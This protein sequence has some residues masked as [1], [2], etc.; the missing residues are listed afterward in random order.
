[1][2]RISTI[3]AFSALL[4]TVF[5]PIGADG[6]VI[7]SG[8][9]DIPI[10][11]TNEGVYIDIDGDSYSGS[12]TVGWDVNPFFG[13]SVIAYGDDFQA[14][15][16]G[17]GNTAPTLSLYPGT[18]VDGSS[19]FAASPGGSFEHMGVG[20][21]KFTGGTESFFGFRFSTN[22]GDGPF[23]GWV[24][25]V[26]TANEP[27]GVVKDWAFENTGAPI[28]IGTIPEPSVAVLAM[29]LPL[30]ILRRKRG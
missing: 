14:V 11:T 13:G 18:M 15:S 24:R 1:M 26:V 19:V 2:F 28:V 17:T 8:I 22:G 30:A 23:F 27:G 5:G 10:P 21:G 12:P 4:A 3:R 29:V 9:Q 7:Y 25:I 20:D 6:A 16:E